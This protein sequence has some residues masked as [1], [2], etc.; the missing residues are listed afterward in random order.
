MLSAPLTCP[1]AS[2]DGKAECWVAGSSTADC[3]QTDVILATRVHPF[4]YSTVRCGDR[5]GVEHQ[6][7]VFGYPLKIKVVKIC[8]FWT[9]PGDFQ[10]G[11]SYF[12]NGH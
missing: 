7:K 2:V 9:T 5:V 12:S 1:D 10:G 3:A 4:Q 8:I 11:V 6:Q